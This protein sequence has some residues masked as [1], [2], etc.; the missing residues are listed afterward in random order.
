MHLKQFGLIGENSYFWYMNFCKSALLVVVLAACHN[1]PSQMAI[2]NESDTTQLQVNVLVSDESQLDTL[3]MVL[4]YADLVSG[5]YVEDTLHFNRLGQAFFQ[6]VL[7]S[8][9]FGFT[10]RFP[11]KCQ[12]S[13]NLHRGLQLTVDLHDNT[14]DWNGD[15]F[16]EVATFSGPD[17][18]LNRF[19]NQYWSDTNRYKFGGF[20]NAIR[21]AKTEE[22]LLSFY[23]SAMQKLPEVLETYSSEG[24]EAQQYLQTAIKS[25][26]FAGVFVGYWRL[27]MEPDRHIIADVVAFEPTFFSGSVL[28][29]YHTLCY[30]HSYLSKDELMTHLNAILNAEGHVPTALDRQFMRLFHKQQLLNA[31]NDDSLV[32]VFYQ[33]KQQYFYELEPIETALLQKRLEK[34]SPAQHDW[35]LWANASPDLAARYTYFRNHNEEFKTEELRKLVLQTINELKDDY[36]LLNNQLKAGNEIFVKTA[37]GNEIDN[38]DGGAKLYCSQFQEVD[39]LLAALNSQ[40]PGQTILI[41]IWGTWCAPCKRDLANCGPVKEQL[42]KYGVQVVHVCTDGFGYLQKWKEVVAELHASGTQLL[43]QKQLADK[44]VSRFKIRSYPT[45]MMLHANGEMHTGELPHISQIKVGDFVKEF[46]LQPN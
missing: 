10:L 34:F 24:V 3:K 8:V 40:F 27:N 29:Y 30:M 37:L 7:P 43:L 28:N 26:I 20:V 31:V 39:S 33:L 2:A 1:K 17:A 22:Q 16:N 14:F 15:H 36:E 21:A 9:L 41:D 42:A 23:D 45:V 35:F 44:V 4:T 25:S 38:L 11:G 13:I 12:G 6:P 19:A 18:S 46:D 5:K 32:T